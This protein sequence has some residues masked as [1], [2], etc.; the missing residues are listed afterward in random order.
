MATSASIRS[1]TFSVS[2]PDSRWVVVRPEASAFLTAA[3]SSLRLFTAVHSPG[4]R[5]PRDEPLLVLVDVL[6]LGRVARD[7]H[8]EVAVGPALH[9][10]ARATVGDHGGRPAEQPVELVG[11]E[12]RLSAQAR[13]GAAWSRAARTSSRSEVTAA[14]LHPAHQPVEPVAVG[15]EEHGDDWTGRRGHHHTCPTRRE[16]GYRRCCSGHW[17]RNRSLNG[18]H[19]RPVRVRLSTRSNTSR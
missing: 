19:S 3:S 8:G 13:A 2:P 18:R 9:D 6:A 1:P 16:A 12:E 11:V 14:W 10:Q 17:T 7:D 4:R 15:A 5:D